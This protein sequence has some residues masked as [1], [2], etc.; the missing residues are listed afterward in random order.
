MRTR[1]FIVGLLLASLPALAFAQEAP[2]QITFGAKHDRDPAVSP[3]GRLLAFASNR[4]GHYNLFVLTFGQ[5]FIK[6][7]V[8]NL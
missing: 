4:T 7:M 6:T 8:Q 5:G 3:D 2:K 1:L